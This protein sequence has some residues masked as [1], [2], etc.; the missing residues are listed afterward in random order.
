MTGNIVKNTTCL[1]KMLYILKNETT[2]FGLYWL[3]SGFHNTLRRVYKTEWGRVD[4][5]DLHASIPWL[6]YF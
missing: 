6:L 5:R 2:C 4:E 1:E 3:S